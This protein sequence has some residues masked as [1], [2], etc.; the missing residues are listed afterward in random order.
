MFGKDFFDLLIFS[1]FEQKLQTQNTC[2]M[3]Q[4]LKSS[5]AQISIDPYKLLTNEDKTYIT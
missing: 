5:G 4:F 2:K 1:S 3:K